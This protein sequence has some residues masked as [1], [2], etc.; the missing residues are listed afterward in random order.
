MSQI[1]NREILLTNG[2]TVKNPAFQTNRYFNLVKSMFQLDNNLIN[3]L[4]EL[5]FF[6]SS[7]TIFPN[8]EDNSEIEKF[9]NQFPTKAIFKNSFLDLNKNSMLEEQQPISSRKIKLIRS[10]IFPEL[11]I[12]NYNEENNNNND[13][14]TIIKVLDLKQELFAKRVPLGH[15]LISGIPGTGKT[16]ILIARAIFLLKTN[17]NWKILIVTYN[18]FLTSKIKNTLLSLEQKMEFENIE[19]SKIEVINFH[20]LAL[21]IANTSVP[22]RAGNSFWEE[23]LPKI[24][25]KKAKPIYDAIL[26]D[27]YQDFRHSWIEITLALLKEFDGENSK[28]EKIKFKNI[29]F[30]GDRLQ[31]IYNPNEINWKQN[32]D[33][34]MRGRSEILKN[35][36]RTSSEHLDKA[37]KLL[38]SDD[39]YAK[40]VD[41]FYEGSEY[42]ESINKSE[43]TLKTFQGVNKGVE[44]LTNLLNS[45]YKVTEILILTPYRKDGDSFRAL[46][47]FNIKN[48]FQVSKEISDNYGTITTYHS[49]KGL[50]SKV[51]ILLNFDKISDK[52][53]LYVGMTR[54]SQ[55]LYIESYQKF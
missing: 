14:D 8:L 28:K 45:G 36:Y 6:F 35:S 24:A 51:V 32:I 26:I 16:V 25:L 44:I 15:Y 54:A 22:Y 4:G 42:L 7:R 40:E 9:F 34:D 47:P 2:K 13:N 37:I 11:L 27:E 55:K 21:R 49:S 17:P 46:L 29:F 31:S 12:S 48:K 30:A 33:L 41:K 1:N 3:D 23:E 10:I 53:L 43:G 18:K 50:E 19:I 39:I 5:N 20:K 38:K 52:K